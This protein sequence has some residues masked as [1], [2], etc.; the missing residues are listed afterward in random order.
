MALEQQPKE[1]L[2]PVYIL[3]AGTAFPT[4]SP[5]TP[6]MRVGAIIFKFITEMQQLLPRN[7]AIHICNLKWLRLNSSSPDNINNY[8]RPY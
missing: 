5:V 2:S 3:R 6:Q 7:E 1:T 8:S 4:R